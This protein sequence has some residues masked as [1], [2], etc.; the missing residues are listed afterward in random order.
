M[1]MRR[2]TVEAFG[3][4]LLKASQVPQVDP[5][6]KQESKPCSTHLWMDGI[7]LDSDV[8]CVIKYDSRGLHPS[9]QGTP[10]VEKNPRQ[11][12][13][14]KEQLWLHWSLCPLHR[15]LRPYYSRV[16]TLQNLSLCTPRF[17]ALDLAWYN[18]HRQPWRWSEVSS[19]RANKT[20]ISGISRPALMEAT[21][22]P[23]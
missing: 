12:V 2:I 15:S 6:L 21:S 22:R 16:S 23:M 20:I 14:E 11:G 7:L 8:L 13:E 18:S 5:W 10:S 4:H 1:E 17:W 19:L 3:H 9:Q